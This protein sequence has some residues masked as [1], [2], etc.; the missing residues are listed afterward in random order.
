[1]QLRTVINCKK[2]HFIK[3]LFL[4]VA[5][6][7]LKACCSIIIIFYFY[8][9]TITEVY[10]AA[11]A[12]GKK[13]NCPMGSTETSFVSSLKTTLASTHVVSAWNNVT[14]TVSSAK[15]SE[16]KLK[17]M[18]FSLHFKSSVSSKYQS[19]ITKT[20]VKTRTGKSP[21]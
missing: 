1:M 7:R 18:A 13:T 4:Y 2:R 19:S 21:Q 15:K 16:I 10:Y 12:N 17:S 3:A 11:M 9:S 20:I 6:I 14:Y 5:Q 8:R